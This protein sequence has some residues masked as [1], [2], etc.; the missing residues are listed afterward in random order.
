MKSIKY[1]LYALSLTI[2]AT[3]M[4]QQF[5]RLG[6]ADVSIDKVNDVTGSVTMIVKPQL[7]RL[8]TDKLIKVIPIIRSANGSDSK[9]LAPYMI[10]GH[11][12][13]FSTLR[14]YNGKEPLY[15][16]GSHRAD[17]IIYEVPWESWMDNSS[18]GCRVETS[19]CCDKPMMT[20]EI[21]IAD[22]DFEVPVIPV[23]ED[24]Q[25]IEPQ[26]K[27]Q[28]EYFLSGSAY[29]NFPV[30]RTEIYPNYMNNPIELRKITASIDSV[31]DNP[32]ATI[33]T[34]AL[35]GY[36]SPEGP[37]ANNVRLAK[38]RTEAVRDYVSKLYDIPASVYVTNSV[39]EDWEGLRKAVEQSALENRDAILKFIDSGYPIEK[40]ND[41]LRQLFPTDYAWLLANIY[42]SLRHTDYVIKYIVRKYS[43]LKEI[44]QVLST[45]PQNL[46]LNEIYL[47]AQSY[48]V[49]SEEYND[50][51]DAAVKLFPNDPT[52]N[53]N[54]ANSAIV[55]GDYVSAEKYLAKAGE[56]ADVDYARGML[57]AKKKDYAAALRYL[58]NCGTPRAKEAIEKINSILNFKGKVKFRSL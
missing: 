26:A 58:Q 53:L 38:G 20:E 8:G 30:N 27:R 35:T 28:K 19:R 11:N 48:E 18:A 55:R 44:G 17:T 21:T 33:D 49:G 51:F 23:P 9:E 50:V 34:I 31:R 1:I 5:D 2:C 22:I 36:A 45:R 37:Y 6:L 4:G 12:Q 47:F 39:P 40:R 46:S 43:D 13:Y 42:P 3:A 56:G 29:V 54:A 25:Y 32:D 14:S 10:A 41:R 15:R 57:A 16:S 7:C 24:L 52:A